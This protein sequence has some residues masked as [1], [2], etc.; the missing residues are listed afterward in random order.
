MSATLLFKAVST[1]THCSVMLTAVSYSGATAVV[2]LHFRVKRHQSKTTGARSAD[3]VVESGNKVDRGGDRHTDRQC[4]S[5]ISSDLELV[6]RF[7]NESS[8]DHL[9][10]LCNLVSDS[11]F[12]KSCR[13]RRS[14]LRLNSSL[15]P[16]HYVA[17]LRRR[18]QRASIVS[19]GRSTFISV[20]CSTGIRIGADVVHFVYLPTD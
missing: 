13:S 16:R 4:R 1:D 6:A 18:R 8:T 12:F 5:D 17:D 10:L 19:T 2:C 3:N 15:R 11:K 9:F 14:S 20:R 7:L